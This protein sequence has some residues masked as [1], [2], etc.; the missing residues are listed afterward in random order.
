MGLGSEECIDCD[1]SN[2]SFQYSPTAGMKGNC[3]VA[4]KCY[5]KGTTSVDRVTGDCICKLKSAKKITLYRNSQ[6]SQLALQS[7]QPMH[8]RTHPEGDDFYEGQHCDSMQDVETSM[9]LSYFVSAVNVGVIVFFMMYHGLKK[10]TDSIFT[11]EEDKRARWCCQVGAICQRSTHI[12]ALQ[13]VLENHS[14]QSDI[15]FK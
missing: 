9:G 5:A 1:N 15:E 11:N 12:D 8:A 4:T 10:V 7:N 2:P 14:H 3:S 6:L 13:S